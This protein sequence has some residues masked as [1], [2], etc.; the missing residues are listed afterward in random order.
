MYHLVIL[1]VALSQGGDIAGYKKITYDRQYETVEA[2]TADIGTATG[3]AR[4][5]FPKE[6]VVAVI[7][8]DLG[9]VQTAAALFLQKRIEKT[10]H[11]LKPD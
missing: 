4:E 10:E 7:C 2:C 6:K 9:K 5:A 3:K 11:T 1:A 8:E